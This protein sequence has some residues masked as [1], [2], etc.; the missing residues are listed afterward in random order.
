MSPEGGSTLTTSAPKS[1]RITAA[2]GAATKVERSTTLSPEKM[3]SLAIGSLLNCRVCF[4][5]QELRGALLEES[6]F[7]RVPVPSA[8][9]RSQSRSRCP[10]HLGVVRTASALRSSP[11][12]VAG[13]I[14]DVAGFAVDAVLRIDDEL[15]VGTLADPLVDAG[16]TIPV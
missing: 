9:F 10:L 1:E 11:C 4:S 16:W 3:L 14:L 8:Q 7:H 12:D 5:G 15:E 6:V 2:A 13:G